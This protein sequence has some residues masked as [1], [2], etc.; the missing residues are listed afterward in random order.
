MSAAGPVEEFKMTQAIRGETH[1]VGK[2]GAGLRA[3]DLGVM[4]RRRPGKF[5]W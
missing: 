2:S 5:A 1:A 3:T 4:A